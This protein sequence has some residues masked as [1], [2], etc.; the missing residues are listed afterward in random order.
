M[1]VKN[2]PGG[3]VIGTFCGCIK[4]KWKLTEKENNLTEFSLSP[5][6]Y[7]VKSKMGCTSASQMRP[8]KHWIHYSLPK[9]GPAVV[10]DVQTVLNV[11][12]LYTPLPMFWAQYELPGSRWTVQ[13]TQMDCSI[14]SFPITPELMLLFGPLLL[15]LTIPMFQ[16][17]LFPMLEHVGLKTPLQKLG[18]GLL[19]VSL[20]VAMS[21]ALELLIA[22]TYPGKVAASECQL[23]IWN[24]AADCSY[25]LHLNGVRPDRQN[26]FQISPMDWHMIRMQSVQDDKV[27]FRLEPNGGQCG[28]SLTGTIRLRSQKS[29]NY[30]LTPNGSFVEYVQDGRQSRV[31]HAKLRILGGPTA[32][33]AEIQL[34]D[35]MSHKVTVYRTDQWIGEEID[36]FPT[37]YNLLSNGTTIADIELT[38]GSLNTIVLMNDH[39]RLHE[40]VGDRIHVLW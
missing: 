33:V 6:Q 40:D 4:V 9:Y 38:S 17:G 20:S 7:A 32:N 19:L 13:A 22:S 12:V 2:P 21:G 18:L 3:N 10:K 14:G 24:G 16:Y 27:P 36:L 31:K 23:T 37:T 39:V 25:T 15:M 11:I 1:Y 28:H 8:P 34:I 26:I 5:H 35:S 30:F 29:V